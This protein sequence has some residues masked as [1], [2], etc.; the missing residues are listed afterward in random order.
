MAFAIGRAEVRRDDAPSVAMS[1]GVTNCLLTTMRNCRV[2]FATGRSEPGG[3]RDVMGF[4][5]SATTVELAMS[6]EPTNA[7]AV[8]A[9]PVLCLSPLEHTT[10]RSRHGYVAVW[11]VKAPRP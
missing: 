2:A 11:S 10:R 5:D 6:F 1:E 4:E 7:L 3:R 8:L 9:A